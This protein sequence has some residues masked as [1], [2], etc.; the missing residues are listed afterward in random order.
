MVVMNVSDDTIFS[1]RLLIL[2]Q[3]IDQND[4]N[5]G[6]FHRWV[7]EFAPHTTSVEVVCLREGSHALPSN[8]NIHSLGKERGGRRWSYIF[9]FYT[10]LWRLR[11]S[12]DSVF[13]HMNSEYLLLGGLLWKMMGK[14]TVLWH[15]HKSMTSIHRI[16][17]KLVEFVATASPESYRLKSAKVR[18]LGHGID[19]EEFS[20]G[21]RQTDGVFR[22]LS[23]GRITPAKG[24]D[25]ILRATKSLM[26]KGVITEVLIV[27]G[28]M[29]ASDVQHEEE[30]K[31]LAS[32]LGLGKVVHFV[33]PVPHTSVIPYLRKSDVFVNCSNTGSLD[34]AVL[35]AMA[36][37]TIPVTSNDGLRTTLE[38]YEATL[39]FPR[40][41]AEALAERLM[42]IKALSE[43]ERRKLSSVLRDIVVRKHGL[44]ALIQKI[45]SLLE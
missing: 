41:D 36:V 24:L 13:V 14:R 6:F 44:S 43:E 22:I 25:I 1:M 11:S 42:H 5:L 23:T 31:K 10:L 18:V 15:T 16:G 39:M 37:G 35:E 20:P 32:D 7:E 28:P 30:L 27:G 2:T 9:H 17:E 26:D 19:T 34:K 12:Y 29:N 4:P 33:G 8:V 21:T 38:G 3:V 45:V 40:A